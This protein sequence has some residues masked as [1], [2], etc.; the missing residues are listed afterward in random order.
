M[1]ADII[2]QFLDKSRDYR[3]VTG[4][5]PQSLYARSSTD[6]SVGLRSRRLQVRFLPGM[7]KT[8]RI[9]IHD[10]RRKGAL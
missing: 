3:I 10:S 5:S 9:R 4:R 2:Q 1:Q 7:P 8:N 6:Q